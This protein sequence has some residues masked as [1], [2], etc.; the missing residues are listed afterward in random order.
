MIDKKSIRE[1]RLF[2]K[3][4]I[5]IEKNGIKFEDEDKAINVLNSLP[6]SYSTFEESLKYTRD[7]L[8][9]N[10]IQKAL[11]SK[12]VDSITENLTQST[13]DRLMVHGRP[14]K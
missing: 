12:E 2:N 10:D 7:S 3:L 1:C 14:K 5:G 4:L 11:I 6:K 13:S 9:L 8:S